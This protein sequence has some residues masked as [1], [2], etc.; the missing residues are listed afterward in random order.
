MARASDEHQGDLVEPEGVNSGSDRMDRPE[1]EGD[2]VSGGRPELA[3]DVEQESVDASDD[4]VA[5]PD[6][7]DREPGQPQGTSGQ[8]AGLMD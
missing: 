4:L 5:A 6:D 3:P 7:A 8:D 2:V 1:D